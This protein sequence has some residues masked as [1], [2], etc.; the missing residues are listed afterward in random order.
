MKQ[1][2]RSFR[3]ADRTRVLGVSQLE[4]WAES[5]LLSLDLRVLAFVLANASPGK[6]FALNVSATAKRL[7]TSRPAVCRAVK[8]L[9]ASKCLTSTDDALDSGVRLYAIPTP[10]GSSEEDGCNSE[11]L[12]DASRPGDSAIATAKASRLSPDMVEDIE[13][14]VE[15]ADAVNY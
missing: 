5:G 1:K 12:V 15:D 11:E 2:S 7:G 3:A 4:A 6:A 10:E 8:R 13:R 14:E 9:V